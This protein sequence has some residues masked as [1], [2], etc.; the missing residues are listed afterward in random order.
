MSNQQGTTSGAHEQE[1]DLILTPKNKFF[2][3]PVSEVWRYRDLLLM[4]V[5][6]DIVTMY[7]QT[8]LGPLWFFIQPIL[9]TVVYMVVFGGIAGISTEGIPRILFYSSGIITWNYFSELLTLTSKTFI[10]NANLF[11]K[12]YFPRIII[13]A[14]KVVS[15]L[16]KFL[17]QFLFFLSVLVYYIVSG[18]DVM[19]NGHVVFVPLLVLL[20]GGMGLGFGIIF[21]SLTF[22]YRDLNFLI[23]FGVQL[24]MYATPVIYPLSAIPEKYKWIIMVNP[25]TYIVEAFRFAFLGAGTWSWM[26]LGYAALWV[27]VLV[28]FGGL[29]FNRVQ[30]TFMDTV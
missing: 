26:G 28:T 5:K 18:T 13:P 27:V 9:T 16:L 19:P 3:F 17:V 29:I 23:Q 11:G 21:S 4:F 20:M 15:G 2:S 10:E 14:S 25:V 1:W 6:R 30:K 12:V 24:F 22:K 7:K 8:I